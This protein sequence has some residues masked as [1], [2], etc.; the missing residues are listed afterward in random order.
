MKRSDFFMKARDFFNERSEFF[1]MMI[2]ILFFGYLLFTFIREKVVDN[3]VLKNGLYNLA[4]IKEKEK[5]GKNKYGSKIFIYTYYVKG[6]KYEDGGAMS[7]D[8][9][10]IHKVGDTIIIKFLPADPQKSTI[11]QGRE[12]K[13]CYGIPPKNGWKK[14]PVCTE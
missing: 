7:P 3:R 9:S 8:L 10:Y 11:I 6:V 12:Y 1:Y 4:I 14:L 13:T 2:S 5:P